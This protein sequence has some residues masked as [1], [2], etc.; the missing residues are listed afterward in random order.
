MS[1]ANEKIAVLC[2]GES[3]SLFPG[4][5]GYA[6]TIAVNRAALWHRC[7]YAVVRDAHTWRWIMEAGGPACRP[8]IVTERAVYQKMVADDDRTATYELINSRLISAPMLFKTAWRRFGSLT[9]IALAAQLL[10]EMREAPA[11][12]PPPGI[13]ELFGMDLAG[14]A[15][16]DGFQDGKQWRDS[17][18]WA[19]ESR[20][21]AEC[22]VLLAAHGI[23]V[24]RR[25]PAEVIG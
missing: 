8:K 1:E 21:L 4:P 3:H 22:T 14:T 20:L 19:K 7:N 5:D 12:W 24:V 25:L 15:D 16:A 2:P 23:E 13:I 18:R 9:A 6:A 17:A 10:S 11:A